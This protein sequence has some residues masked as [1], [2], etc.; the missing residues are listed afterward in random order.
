[1]AASQYLT[2]SSFLASDMVDFFVGTKR[3]RYHL[4][5]ELLCDRSDYFKA[6]FHGRFSE[7]TSNELYLPDDDIA[8]FGLFVN[9]LYG[10]PLKEF[11]TAEQLHD[12]LA[13]WVLS[14]MLLIEYLQ[15]LTVDRIRA[16]YCT[17]GDEVRAKD[18][19]SI[20]R[21]PR[22]SL[23]TRCMAGTLAQQALI[24]HGDGI[25]NSARSGEL[26]ELMLAGGQ[27]AC[28]VSL[29]LMPWDPYP[30][31]ARLRSMLSVCASCDYHRHDTTPICK[32]GT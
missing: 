6:A 30:A 17:T 9:W 8:A 1:M 5:K 12:Y 22:A 26:T 16:Y 23:L 25:K 27:L 4:H 7:S 13:L 20:H 24:E 19:M 28:D 15:K 2:S 14:D 18:V 10:S 31:D 3:K 32:R 29:Y 21:H 11:D